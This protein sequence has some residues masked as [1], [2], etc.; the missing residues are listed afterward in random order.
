[1]NAQT[2]AAFGAIQET[3]ESL[4]LAVE[5]LREQI[6]LTQAA[7]V[8]LAK[9]LDVDLEVT[10]YRQ[11]VEALDEAEDGGWRDLPPIDATG[12]PGE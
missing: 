2:R 3:L 10:P 9:A 12:R 4:L 8:S 1:M 6:L 7:T 5:G 11:I